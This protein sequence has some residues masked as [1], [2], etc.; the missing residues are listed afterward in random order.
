MQL[1]R[2]IATLATALLLTGCVTPYQSS[3][4]T[5]GYNDKMISADVYEVSFGGNGYTPKQTVEMYFYYRCAEMTLNAGHRY[6]SLRPISKGPDFG[7][8]PTKPDVAAADGDLVPVAHWSYRGY[9][10][11]FSQWRQLGT[12]LLGYDAQEVIR[13]LDAF[14]KSSGESSGRLPD[15]LVFD[16]IR[17]VSRYEASGASQDDVSRRAPTMGDLDGLLPPK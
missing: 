14:V 5:G 15:L 4:L 12:P 2:H 8:L 17:G 1:R 16:P 10:R 13:N 9:M 3:S 7:V 11:V 6:F